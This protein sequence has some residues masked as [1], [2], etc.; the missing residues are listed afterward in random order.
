MSMK[1]LKKIALA[2]FFIIIPLISFCENKKTN[3]N[4]I[5][6]V[7]CNLYINKGDSLAALKLYG[8]ASS[9]YEQAIYFNPKNQD[10]YFKYAKLYSVLNPKSSIETLQKLLIADS[11]VT[12]AKKEIAELYYNIEDIPNATKYYADYV[13]SSNPS[14]DDI[15]RYSTI[16]FSNKNY[17]K[18]LQYV[19]KFLEKDS[20]HFVLRRL[21]MYNEFE[22][23]DTNIY[24]SAEKFMNGSDTSKYIYYDYL[25]Y[26]KILKDKKEYAKANISLEKALAL[27]STSVDLYKNIA[28]NYESLNNYEKA[29]ENYLIFFEKGKVQL[30][31]YLILGQAYYFAGNNIS[32]QQ[33]SIKRI[34]NLQKAD[35][36]FAIIVE[37]IP[38][39]A[40][41]NFW[42]ARANSSIDI[43]T[44]L[45]LAKPYYEA[46]LVILER[47]NK[48]KKKIIEC[49]S[50]L[51][52]YYF[53]KNEMTTSKEY[54]NKILAIDPKN[55]TALKALKGIK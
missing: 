23:K 36:L 38:T 50:Y 52:Y 46:A 40:I 37:K 25:Y 55:D 32:L 19:K 31:D 15:A 28:S 43:E 49:Y 7:R 24:A 10:A 14:S 30:A 29:I 18:S 44:T 45:G 9:M 54:W 6:T 51:G 8:E 42:R 2:S 1:I 20:N 12:I 48:D 27:D 22:L 39:N 35:S 3:E 21:R 16:L 11:T 47:E 13:E 4:K 34:S 26:S 17:E 41:G 33:D 5:D 53:V